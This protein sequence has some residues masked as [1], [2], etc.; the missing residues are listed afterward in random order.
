MKTTIKLVLV[1]CLF[2]SISFADDG[3][4]GPGGKTCTPS[5]CLIENQPFENVNSEPASDD[6]VY[7][8]IQNYL[9]SIFG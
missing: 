2:N 3:E 6:S 9:N 8:F 1:V 7:T 4:M 5:P